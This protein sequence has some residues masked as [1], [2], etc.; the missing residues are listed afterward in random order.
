MDFSPLPF[1]G[2]MDV[3]GAVAVPKPKPKNLGGRPKGLTPP[4]RPSV[5]LKG[6]LEWRDW[7]KGLADHMDMPATVV[8]DQ[9]LKAY[10]KANGYDEDFPGR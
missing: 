5:S 1:S 10:A 2:P 6:S 7:L 9:A 3:P 8:I 4:K